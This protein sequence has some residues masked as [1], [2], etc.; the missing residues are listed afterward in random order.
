MRPHILA[1]RRL[2]AVWFEG[3]SGQYA[4]LAA[5]LELTA[6]R[7]C[8]QWNITVEKLQPHALR[9]A[10]G[11]SSS[12]ADNHWKLLHWAREV[13]L[14]PD[15]AELVML[16]ADTFITGPLDAIFNE[17][18]DV[19]YT[20]RQSARYPLNAGVIAVRGGEAARAFFDQWVSTDALFLR[21]LKAR[22][23]WRHVYGGQNQASL[24]AVLEGGSARRPPR[25]RIAALPCLRWN[26]EDT[27]WSRWADEPVDPGVTSVVHVKSHLREHAFHSLTIPRRPSDPL[28]RGTDRLGLAWRDLDR[29]ASAATTQAVA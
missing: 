2:F 11:G 14:L 23:P 3:R 28:W 13:A 25:A 7:C 5:V 6:R 22:A 24:G 17:P 19:A 15:G 1:V 29:E 4:R 8:P 20:E 26:C 16:D 9:G 27:C 10:G 21:D 12:A 18:F